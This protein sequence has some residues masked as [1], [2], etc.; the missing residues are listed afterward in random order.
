MA[1]V[2]SAW[3]QSTLQA[4]LG[5][6]GDPV[7]KSKVKKKKA[8][9]AAQWQ[10]LCLQWPTEGLGVQLLSISWAS[11]LVLKKLG[12]IIFKKPLRTFLLMGFFIAI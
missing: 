7:P 2:G 9:D 1:R 6:L 4:S 10:F 5:N 8:G 12:G 3:T 11:S